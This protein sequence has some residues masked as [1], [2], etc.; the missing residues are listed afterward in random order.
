MDVHIDGGDFMKCP[1]CN[2]EMELGYIQSR[3]GVTW[4]PKKRLIPAFSILRKG[5]VSLANGAADYSGCVY[6]YKC[7]ECKKVIIDYSEQ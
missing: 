7:G 5:S 4:T 2:K 1:Y 3:D 6:A